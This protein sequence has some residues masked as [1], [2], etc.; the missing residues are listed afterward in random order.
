MPSHRFATASRSP[1]APSAINNV[2]SISVPPDRHPLP[3]AKS[4][5]KVAASRFHARKK[6]TA[7]SPPLTPLSTPTFATRM[8]GVALAHYCDQRNLQVPFMCEDSHHLVDNQKTDKGLI[9]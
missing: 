4:N 1:P 7:Y 6:N 9:S 8:F 3:T 5:Q 2:L